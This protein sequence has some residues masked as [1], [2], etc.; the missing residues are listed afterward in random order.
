MESTYYPEDWESE[1]EWRRDAEFIKPI[2]VRDVIAYG[3]E[4]GPGSVTHEVLAMLRQ[5]A[6]DEQARR[7]AGPNA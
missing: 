4:H 3:E 7:D 1:E 2:N 5:K 6:L